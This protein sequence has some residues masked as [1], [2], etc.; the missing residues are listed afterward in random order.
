MKTHCPAGQ[1]GCAGMLA[2]LG[3]MQSAWVTPAPSVYTPLITLLPAQLM[4]PAP[5]MALTLK[6]LVPSFLQIF[7]VAAALGVGAVLLNARRIPEGKAPPGASTS[8]V[9]CGTAASV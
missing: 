8:R 5:V 7:A 3:G 6:Q 4:T 1:S 2:K 9:A